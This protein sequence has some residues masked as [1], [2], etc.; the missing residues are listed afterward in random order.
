MQFFKYLILVFFF[1][2]ISNRLY[3]QLKI[4]P[5]YILNYEFKFES[6]M[7]GSML[8]NE[9][10]VYFLNESEAFS[11]KEA[12]IK[13]N[14]SVR[15]NKMKNLNFSEDMIKKFE[16]TLKNTQ[17]KFDREFFYYNFLKGKFIKHI[18]DNE[19]DNYFDV[20]DS[21]KSIEWEVIDSFSIINN[22]K[23]QYA[24]GKDNFQNIYN[25]W[26]SNEIPLPIGPEGINGLPGLIL[27]V[28]SIDATKRVRFFKVT[29]I[30]INPD[31][32]HDFTKYEFSKIKMSQIEYSKKAQEKL[33]TLKLMN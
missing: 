27:E 13:S 8:K 21:T 7:D 16:N 23:V 20:E 5:K 9:K 30:S 14:D 15:I 4:K 24:K 28:K 19:T 29:S 26:F 12:T 22:S 33:N 25:A 31:I 18:Y 11:I 2:V 3:A 17:E 1:I 32:V 10:I 6:P